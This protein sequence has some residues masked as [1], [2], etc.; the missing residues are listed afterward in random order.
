MRAY[1]SI[2]PSVIATFLILTNQIAF[3]GDVQLKQYSNGG[4]YEGEFLNGKQHGNGK[5]I[6]ADGYEYS[7]QW[8]NG[9]IEGEGTAKYSD[10]SIYTGSFKESKPNG[11]GKLVFLNGGS[12]EGTWENGN[13]HGKGT[14][15]YS[16]GDNYTGNFKNTNLLMPLITTYS[17]NM[18]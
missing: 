14:I 4:I 10:G 13:F 16:N 5:Y 6:S 11:I 7:G 17:K 3:A 1:R 18:S 9:I 15:I 2:L 8:V 12:Y